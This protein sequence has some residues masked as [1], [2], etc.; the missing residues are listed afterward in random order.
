MSALHGD[1]RGHDAIDTFGRDNVAVEPCSSAAL[2]STLAF[3]CS[4]TEFPQSCLG[5]GSKPF[6]YTSSY[7]LA[8]TCYLPLEKV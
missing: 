7:R 8:K 2:E 1:G 4:V 5:Y 3:I 6:T